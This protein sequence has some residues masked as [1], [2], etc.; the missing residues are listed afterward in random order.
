MCLEPK[1]RWALP[2]KSDVYGLHRK[3]TMQL[4]SV[5]ACLQNW[6]SRDSKMD[7]GTLTEIHLNSLFVEK[8][9][10]LHMLI[11]LPQNKEDTIALCV[12]PHC[13]ALVRH[14]CSFYFFL[15]LTFALM[16]IV[17][18]F[19]IKSF[20]MDSSSLL[21]F[22]GTHQAIHIINVHFLMDPN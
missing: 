19:L 10:L 3:Q 18:T 13:Q 16:V 9:S 7:F 14:R 20:L 8:A 17:L 4:R 1:G 12:D 2:L 22:Q 15:F 5:K 6:I 11:L 21:L